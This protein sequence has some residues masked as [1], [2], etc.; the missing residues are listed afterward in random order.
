LKIQG[1]VDVDRE[2]IAQRL[3]RLREERGLSQ[4]QVAEPGLT[5]AYICRIEAGERRPSVKAL[6]LIAP[7]L[8]V[9]PEYLESGRER[10]DLEARVIDAELD[11]RLGERESALEQFRSLLSELEQMGERTLVERAR[12]GLAL[13]RADEGGH[14]EAA[15]LLEAILDR[16]STPVPIRP[17]LYAAL[18]RAYAAA[19]EPGRAVELFEYCLS[20]IRRAEIVDP[21]LYVRFA[22]YLSYALTDIG[23]IAGANKVLV[24]ALASAPR[25]TDPYSRIRLYWSL[26]RLY[27]VQG[28]PELAI[29]YYRKA[30]AALEVTEDRL[31]LARAHEACASALLDQQKPKDARAHL[32]TAEEIY[33]S[34]ADPS[35]RGSLKVEWARLEIQSGHTA[36]ARRLALDALDLL[37]A[38]GPDTD[39]IGDAWRTLAETLAATGE[40][41]HAESAYKH[42]ITAL[43]A[44][45]PVKYLADAHRSY[46]D[47]LHSQGRDR[48]AFAHMK[49]AATVTTV[50]GPDQ[51]AGP[52]ADEVELPEPAELP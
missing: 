16:G 14:E 40:N 17:D 52:A 33:G 32:E 3:R 20:E 18:G 12:I 2:G 37:E 11:L 15:T 39:D 50:A 44:G 42:A 27:G 51:T 43:S 19:G 1:N 22:T 4:R 47:F 30:I 23:D 10:A 7:R 28:P 46:A 38:G 48:E 49:R 35:L 31:H 5:G 26:G 24:E 13:G 45:A 34:T 6:R 41:D 9:S 29:A 21:D 8:G 25:L 36:E